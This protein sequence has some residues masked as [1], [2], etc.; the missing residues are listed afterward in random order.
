MEE[1]K[2]TLK[3]PAKNCFLIHCFSFSHGSALDKMKVIMGAQKI[4]DELNRNSNNVVQKNVKKKDGICKDLDK[5]IDSFFKE[6]GIRKGQFRIHGIPEPI[7]W[8]SGGR[9]WP[10]PG[11]VLQG[12]FPACEF[13]KCF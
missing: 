11:T 12:D 2:T 3:V 7:K 6:V 9:F 4:C 1:L 10:T 13:S 8:S 5:K